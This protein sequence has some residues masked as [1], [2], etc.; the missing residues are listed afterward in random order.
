MLSVLFS[1][2]HINALGKK[3]ILYVYSA[4]LLFRW[5]IME[6]M[7]MHQQSAYDRL[8]RW[9]KDE[10]HALKDD[11]DEINPLLVVAGM[12]Q[13]SLSVRMINDLSSF[14]KFLHCRRSSQCFLGLSIFNSSL[15]LTRIFY[16]FSHK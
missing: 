11:P 12:Y 15:A 6:L 16:F 13:F 3:Y 14:I 4:D 5:E 10:F 2:A 7:S 8:Y 1:C 9:V